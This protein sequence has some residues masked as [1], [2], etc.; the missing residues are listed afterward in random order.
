QV[1]SGIGSPRFHF[2]S[3]VLHLPPM[4]WQ[5]LCHAR[6]RRYIRVGHCIFV[7]YIREATSTACA[8]TWFC[9]KGLRHAFFGWS[10]GL[11]LVD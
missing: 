8:L 2:C 7:G 4:R 10:R 11:A 9:R 6:F 1:S 5:Q 3:Y